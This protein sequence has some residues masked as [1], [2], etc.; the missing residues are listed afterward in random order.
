[1]TTTPARGSNDGNLSEFYSAGRVT[2][3]PEPARRPL[4]A[5]AASIAPLALLMRRPAKTTRRLGDTSAD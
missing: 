5:A 4:P 1:M 2:L 3:V